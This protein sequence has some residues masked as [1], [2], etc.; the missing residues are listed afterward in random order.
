MRQLRSTVLPFSLRPAKSK[1]RAVSPPPPPSLLIYRPL[2]SS[3]P[4]KIF[5]G[6]HASP[7]TL[8]RL[9]KPSNTRT[10]AS[11][12][13]CPSSWKF[14]SMRAFVTDLGMT[15]QPLCSPQS[16]STCWTLRPLAAASCAS[17]ASRYSGE[18]VEPRQE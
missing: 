13:P 9:V 3:S 1:P 2:Y 15:D 7:Q 6:S 11:L 14:P 17:V 5:T 18:S 8:K 10:S 12:R 16:S 4:Q